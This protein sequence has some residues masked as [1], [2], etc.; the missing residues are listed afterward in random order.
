MRFQNETKHI[1]IWTFIYFVTI[2]DVQDVKV[3]MFS[4]QLEEHIC[5]GFLCTYR[6]T[7][8]R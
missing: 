8:Q 2:I 5:Q 6:Q 3:N 1:A 7:L 4:S